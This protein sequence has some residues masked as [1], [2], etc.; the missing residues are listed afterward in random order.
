MLVKTLRNMIL[1]SGGLF[2]LGSPP[3]VDPVAQFGESL[4]I[5]FN[6]FS[7]VLFNS[8]I[9]SATFTVFIKKT[10]PPRT[11][12]HSHPHTQTHTHTNTHRTKIITTVQFNHK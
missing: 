2:N 1:V 11:Q 3:E 7:F 9:V 4:E 12:T 10:H 5:V 6:P 8:F